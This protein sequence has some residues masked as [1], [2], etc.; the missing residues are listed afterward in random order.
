MTALSRSNEYS[1]ALE[2]AIRRQIFLNRISS[3][4][5]QFY[6][7]YLEQYNRLKRDGVAAYIPAEMNRL[8]SDLSRIRTLLISDPE[9]A[10]ELSYT[11]GSYIRSMSSLASAAREQFDRAER[12]RIENM[13]IERQQHQSELVQ[14]Y[15]EILKS[16]TNSIVVNYSAPDLQDLKK[17]IDAGILTDKSELAVRA[18]AIITNAEKKADEWKSQTINSNRQA[19]AVEIIN[20]AEARLRNENIED[21]EKTQQFL[22]RIN[23]LRSGLANGI[24]DAKAVEKQI[25]VLENEVDD[26]LI[27]EETRRET[28][29]AI[30]KQLRNQ[31]FTVEKPKLIQMNGKN[32]VKIVAKKPSGKRAICNIDLH[33]K[34]AYKFDNYEGMTCLKDIKKFN[35]D[36]Q[37][38]YSIKLSDERV[39][40]NNPDKLERDANSTPQTD[41]RSK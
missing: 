32:Y 38:I 21:K 13:R 8:E 37:Q 29:K 2:A 20:E 33:G 15:F 40:W 31:E 36:L 1:Y 17:K 34:I 35:V 6:S 9:E 41:R 7:R 11:V 22:D 23:Q 14:A 5:E 10:R 24:V 4:T 30:I 28:V 27:S 25:T 18:K 16:I 26:T 12:I 39:L 19:N 3:K